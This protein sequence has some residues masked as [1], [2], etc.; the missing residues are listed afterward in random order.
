MRPANGPLIAAK[1]KN[2]EKPVIISVRLQLWA[3]SREVT[4]KLKLIG[5]HPALIR[6]NRKQASSTQ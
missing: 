4:K 3:V 2:N 5:P 1:I 6:F